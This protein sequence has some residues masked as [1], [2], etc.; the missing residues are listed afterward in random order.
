MIADGNARY[1]INDLVPLI[2]ECIKAG[3][4]VKM[5]VTGVS[6]LPLLAD[7]RDSVVLGAAK[8]IH[9]YDIVLHRRK[10]GQYILHRVIKIKDGVLTI[11]GDFELEKEYPVYTSQ[12]IARAEGFERKGKYYSCK[13]LVYRLYSAVWV[14]IFPFRHKAI[15]LISAV[16]RVSNGKA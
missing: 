16:R 13:S 3:K 7:R 5:R 15:R 12:V 9:R 4:S 6:M 2:T 8:K 14:A 1:S 11:A 10:S